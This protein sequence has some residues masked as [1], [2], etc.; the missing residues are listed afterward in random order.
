VYV[1]PSVYMWLNHFSTIISGAA[2]LRQSY[3]R[4]LK[5]PPQNLIQAKGMISSM[6][7][8]TRKLTY[9]LQK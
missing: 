5:V 6:N 7:T 3:F 2:L 8:P 4:T 9:S 1:L